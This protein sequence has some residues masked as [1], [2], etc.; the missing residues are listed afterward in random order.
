MTKQIRHRHIDDLELEDCSLD[1]MLVKLNKYK[2]QYPTE[3]IEVSFDSSYGQY[4]GPDHMHIC[5]Y[6]EETDEEY[7]QRL[8]Y[9]REK[10]ETKERKELGRLISAKKLNPTNQLR[11]EELKG[12]YLNG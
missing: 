10:L 11:L 5:Y 6:S 1:E 9:E 2:E 4:S 3:N 8:E 7:S 12:K